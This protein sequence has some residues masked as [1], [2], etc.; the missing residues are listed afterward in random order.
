MARRLLPVP[1][2][3]DLRPRFLVE[4]D[5]YSYG[6]VVRIQRLLWRGFDMRYSN[7]A[8]GRTRQE[9]ARNLVAE[10]DRD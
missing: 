7:R 3:S 4:V 2:E 6:H 5:G 1:V 10:I 8:R 9:C